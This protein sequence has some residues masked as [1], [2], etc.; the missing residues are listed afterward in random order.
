MSLY[1]RAQG[2]NGTPTDLYTNV[3]HEEG[4]EV[5]GI[6]N[7]VPGHEET[8]DYY[9]GAL[10]EG[11]TNNQVQVKENDYL[12][13]KNKP[14]INGVTLVGNKTTT[15]FKIASSVVVD[16]LVG[17][18]GNPIIAS[19]LEE[20]QKYI[21]SGLV[22]SSSNNVRDFRVPRKEYI[23]EKTLYTTVLW[24]ANPFATEQYTITFW[25]EGTKQPLEQHIQLIT[26]DILATDYGFEK[27]TVDG[28]DI[29]VATKLNVDC[30]SWDPKEG[31][32]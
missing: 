23:V 4:S 24:D 16:E 14:T 12:Y 10:H 13:L 32:F 19:E 22:K 7:Q 3:I 5:T 18:D 2:A 29:I 25:L 28:Q 6:Y 9:V 21:L 30:G 11:T 17:K 8:S 31:L 1:Q 15:D 26:K 27:A 20:G